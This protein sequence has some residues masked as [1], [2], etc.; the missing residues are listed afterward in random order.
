VYAIDHE[1]WEDYRQQKRFYDQ[2][3]AD[4]KKQTEPP[5]VRQLKINDTTVEGARDV[6]VNNPN[7]LLLVADE[8]SGW[9]GNI[10]KYSGHRGGMKD[11]AFWLGAYDGG[12]HTVNRANQPTLHIRNLA[13]SILGG[14]Q[15]DTIRRIVAEMVD[16][17][18]IQRL[19]PIILLRGT[20]SKD[21]PTSQSSEA[22]R[23]LVKRLHKLDKGNLPFEFGDDDHYYF[24]DGASALRQEL[25]RK[26]IELASLESINKK[27]AAHIGK[28]DGIFVRLC[29]IWNCIEGGPGRIPESTARRVANFLHQ[30]LLPHAMAFYA[31]TLGLSDDHDQLTNV[32]GFIL[33][34]QL[35]WVTNRDVARGNRDMRKLKKH[36]VDNIFHQ[37]E[38]LGW[39]ERV[40]GNRN[41]DPPRWFVN[42]EVHERFAE[43]GKREAER[44]AR[45]RAQI[46]A[47]FGR[48]EPDETEL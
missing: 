48:P 7:G 34:H 24:D 41:T 17:G 42:P 9:F 25:E 27:L 18:L 37:L 32:A 3:P 1:L 5:T 6:L 20:I 47:L 15:P 10:D 36:E 35:K 14:I 33:A 12:P 43:R 23:T 39:V 31:G 4:E 30:F 29:L 28:Y 13:V 19:I 16:D 26:H 46:G 8:L 38:A 11:R 40:A 21:E 45:E 2:L 22:Y 44:R